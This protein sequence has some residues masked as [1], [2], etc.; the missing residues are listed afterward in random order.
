MAALHGSKAKLRLFTTLG[1][2]GQGAACGKQA[3]GCVVEAPARLAAPPHRLSLVHSAASRSNRAEEQ[4]LL[5]L[6]AG[7]EQQEELCQLLTPWFG[8]YACSY[9]ARPSFSAVVLTFALLVNSPCCGVPGLLAYV[10][11]RHTWTERQVASAVAADGCRQLVILGGGFRT[12]LWRVCDTGHGG[13][14]VQVYEV[15]SRE[16]VERK[17]AL[18]QALYPPGGAPPSGAAH[19][20]DGRPAAPG[21]RP[22]LVAADWHNVKAL[23][24]A[25]VATGFD[26]GRRCCLVAQGLLPFLP[27]A[28]V[29]ELL[30]LLFDFLHATALEGPEPPPG[31]ERYAASLAAKGAPLLS[32]LRPSYS[33]APGLGLGCMPADSWALQAAPARHINAVVKALQPH[34]FRLTDLVPPAELAKAAGA[35]AAAPTLPFFSLVGAARISDRLLLRG[36][37]P[38]GTAAACDEVGAAGGGW[39]AAVTDGLG[40]PSCFLAS[41]WRSAWAALTGRSAAAAAVAASAPAGQEEAPTRPG[42]AA[43]QGAATDLQAPEPPASPAQ[44][45]SGPASPQGPR[46]DAERQHSVEGWT[47]N[48]AVGS[49]RKQPRAART[50]SGGSGSSTGSAGGGAGRPAAPLDLDRATSVL[51]RGPAPPAWPTGTSAGGRAAVGE[52]ACDAADG[53][54]VD[55]ELWARYM[56][57]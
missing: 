31:F 23:V 51:P 28:Q 12:S 46:T 5:E 4:L 22:T 8:L 1:E 41:A 18:L 47:L 25:L 49:P 7:V 19:P 26:P 11:A 15:D 9:K 54:Y 14:Q 38:A 56:L 36:P 48:T 45:D 21:P 3:H 43:P 35:G 20:P 34:H 29:E 32:G 57:S 33:G 6:A 2:E 55:G 44:A 53:E 17:K 40:G 27:P 10:A 42:G 13:V 39:A 50:D 24:P 16:I 52:V 37:A 30:R